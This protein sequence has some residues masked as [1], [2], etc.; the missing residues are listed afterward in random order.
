M[1][2][3][4]V[5]DEQRIADFVAQGFTAAGHLITHAADG[6]Q[7]LAELADNKHDV[8]IL[9]L[10]LPIK[11]GIEVLRSVRASGRSIPVLILSAKV[12]LEDRLRGFEFGA[13]DYVP[14]PFYIEELI[15]RAQLLVA[16]RGGDTEA[17]IQI[18]GLRLDRLKR[19]VSW[20]DGSAALSSREYRLLELLMRSPGTLFSRQ[21]ILQQVWDISFDPQTNVVDVC[22]QRLKRK[23][24][25]TDGSHGVQIEAV[26][27]VGYRLK[28]QGVDG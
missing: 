14:K 18:G 19:E 5:E 22:V 1:N 27:G 15:A 2:V 28:M 9:D 17:S 3:L 11:D 6:G 25:T 4:L 13:D 20:R 7:A 8:M 10:M 26:R 24:E 12:E 16:R 23:T 21:Q